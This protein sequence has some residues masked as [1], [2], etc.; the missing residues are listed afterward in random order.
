MTFGGT[1][2]GV[3]IAALAGGATACGAGAGSAGAPAAAVRDSAGVTIV[4]NVVADSAAWRWLRLEPEL[5]IGSV[6]G[7]GPTSLHRVVG[8]VWL[9]EDR[10]AVANG[11][12]SEI[13]LFD[14]AGAHV[15][16]FGRAGG[17][18]GEFQALS[19][20]ARGV[21]DSI[22]AWDARARRVTV[23]GP[24]GTYARDMQLVSDGSVLALAGT[25]GGG[26]VLGSQTMFDSPVESSGLQRPPV[27][28]ASF[29]AAGTRVAELGRHAGDER[30]VRIGDRTVEIGLP[31]F[32]RRTQFA[33]HGERVIVATQER[34]ELLVHDLTGRLTRI[35]RTGVVPAAVTDADLEAHISRVVADMPPDRAAGVRGGLEG[36][37]RVPRKPAHGP[38]VISDGGEFWLSD[39]PDPA[40][41]RADWTVFDADGVAQA[42]VRLPAG[43]RL[44]GVEGDRLYGV[45]RDELDVEYVRVYRVDGG[46]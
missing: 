22:L 42:R 4:E 43:F 15:A 27:A 7:E 24:D 28:L 37:L 32:G 41:Q 19:G 13:R 16:T 40:T 5:A 6:A 44:F 12:S 30:T 3:A 36:M 33:G 31:P 18:P 29:D 21:A 39:F 1:W 23:F 35:V 38:L 14:A 34:G 17:G 46:R 20:V 45:A 9:G 25:L 26:M 2:R 8:V 11:G 10:L